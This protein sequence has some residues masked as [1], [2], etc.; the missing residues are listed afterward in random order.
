MGCL[1]SRGLPLQFILSAMLVAVTIAL[2]VLARHVSINTFFES[3]NQT[4]FI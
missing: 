1:F 2:S 3:F 4:Y